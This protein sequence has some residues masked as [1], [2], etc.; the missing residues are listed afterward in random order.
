MS[1]R[2]FPC[3]GKGEE[4]ALNSNLARSD[5]ILELAA[6]LQMYLWH[7]KLYRLVIKSRLY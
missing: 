4:I 1:L 5:W 7:F 6:I 3:V 2:I